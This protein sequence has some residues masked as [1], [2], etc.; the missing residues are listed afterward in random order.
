[1]TDKNKLNEFSSHYRLNLLPPDDLKSECPQNLYTIENR[2]AKGLKTQFHIQYNAPNYKIYS[3]KDSIPHPKGGWAYNWSKME[4]EQFKPRD[5]A[6]HIYDKN[7]FLPQI[8]W[9]TNPFVSAEMHLNLRRNVF[10]IYHVQAHEFKHLLAKSLLLNLI[11]LRGL[12]VFQQMRTENRVSDIDMFNV[13]DIT[14]G[15]NNWVN[16][17]IGNSTRLDLI[18]NDMRQIED[19]LDTIE[20]EDNIDRACYPIVD[21]LLDIYGNYLGDI[22]E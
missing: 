4:D 19:L 18:K 13:T 2:F 6:Q 12:K 5:I 11:Y 15:M 22:H 17:K 16:T 1:M 7:R 3:A 9:E 20:N 21:D 14:D 10:D 8:K